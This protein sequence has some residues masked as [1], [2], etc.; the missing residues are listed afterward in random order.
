MSELY[1]ISILILW[2]M[3]TFYKLKERKL[4]NEGSDTG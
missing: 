2:A 3:G 4:R 1:A